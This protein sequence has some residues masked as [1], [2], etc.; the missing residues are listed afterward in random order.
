MRLGRAA[1]YGILSTI[2]IAQQ[3]GRPVRG[4]D[5]AVSCQVPLEYLLKIL[6]RLV[7]AHVLRS[8]RGRAGGFLLRKP[9]ARTNM[10]EIVQAI[11][12]PVEGEVVLNGEFGNLARSRERLQSVCNVVADFSRRQFELVTVAEL[13]RLQ[14]TR[15]GVTSLAP[16]GVGA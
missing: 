9:A 14:F 4:R 8:E 11:E 12:G 1:S 13:L 7:R 16:T 5:I 3:L 10:L 2:Y 15:P 6:Q